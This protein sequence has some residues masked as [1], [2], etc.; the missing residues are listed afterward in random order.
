MGPYVVFRHLSICED[1][2][3]NIERIVSEC[4]AVIRKT[5]R[6]R[7]AI[8]Q[9]IWE[10]CSRYALRLDPRISTC[11]LQS[12]SERSKDTLI[13]RRLTSEVGI[14]FCDKSDRLRSTGSAL[15]LDPDAIIWPTRAR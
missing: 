12:V 4:P 2:N 7:R 11:V 15:H 1:A 5:R 14:S 9:N 3:K 8:R 6:A 13:V 10:Q